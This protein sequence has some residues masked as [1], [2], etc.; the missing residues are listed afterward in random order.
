MIEFGSNKSMISV[1]CG[2]CGAELPTRSVAYYNLM[3]CE[4]NQC[5]LGD[6]CQDCKLNGKFEY[7][8]T[9][10]L[11]YVPHFGEV[12][13][14][15]EVSTVSFL[16]IMEDRFTYCMKILPIEIKDSLLETDLQVINK[17]RFELVDTNATLIEID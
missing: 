15:K 11:P 4:L 13:T 8:N 1:K 5:Y 7:I 6:I 17:L 12:V 10:G 14:P 9:T 3:D 16:E 2:C